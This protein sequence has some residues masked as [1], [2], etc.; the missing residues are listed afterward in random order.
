ML[1]LCKGKE[2]LKEGKRDMKKILK[3]ANEWI[4]MT[5]LLT[6]IL[7]GASIDGSEMAFNIAIVLVIPIVISLRLYYVLEEDSKYI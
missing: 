2:K 4:L 3:T 5:L 7:M 1:D 6:E